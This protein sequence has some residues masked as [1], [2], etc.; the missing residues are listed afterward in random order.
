MDMQCALDCRSL[1]G[2]GPVWDVGEQRLYWVDI[3]R[4]QIHRFAADTGADETWPMPEDIGA[5]AP[6]EGGGLVVA[7]RSGFH[8]YDL[9]DRRLLPAALPEDEPEHN[10]FNDGK[11]DRQGRFW[12]GTMDEGEKLPTG[13]L[14][15]LQPNLAC[16]NDGIICSNALCWSPDSRVMYY[17][18]SG[19]RTAG[20]GFRPG[21]RRDRESPRFRPDR[22][23]G[24]HSRRRHRRQRGVRV[25]RALGRLARR[26]LRSRGSRRPD[27][28]AA[29]CAADLSDVRRLR[30]R[31][32]VRHFGLDRTRRGG[33]CGPAAGRQPLRREG[34][35]EGAARGALQGLDAC[36]A[37]SSTAPNGDRVRVSIP[38]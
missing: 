29:G 26:P 1:L 28:H 12:A 2:E 6:R 27:D 34:R 23:R 14:F 16:R 4:R 7:L 15:R 17:A 35:G 5:L 25:D 38:A 10:R 3:K 36:W 24:W 32:H 8:F 33:A 19:R 30:P 20:V 21:N 9:V 31:H 22:R 37:M 11:A 13:G 18:D